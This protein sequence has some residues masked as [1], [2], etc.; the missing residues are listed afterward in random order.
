MRFMRSWSI[1]VGKIF[2]IELRVH[3]T[4]LFLLLFVW[5]TEL[6]VHRQAGAGPAL[7]LVGIIFGSV[8]LHELGHALVSTREGIPVKSIVLLPIGGIT[9]MDESQALSEN[10]GKPHWQRDI[11]IAVAGPIANLLVALIAGSVILQVV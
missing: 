2:G 11:R 8:I 7:A 5:G 10:S 9:T 3:L 6:Q 4:F 1:S